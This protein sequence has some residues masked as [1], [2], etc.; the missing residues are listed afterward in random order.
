[1]TL[2]EARDN[3]GRRVVYSPHPGEEEEGVI[4]YASGVHVFVR[5][6]GNGAPKAT[7]P[8]CLTLKGEAA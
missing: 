4:V 2:D 3:A 7:P 6:G 8:H 5:Y 1:M